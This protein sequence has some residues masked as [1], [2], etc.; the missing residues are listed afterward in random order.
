MLTPVRDGDIKSLRKAVQKLNTKLGPTSDPTF[1]DISL[2]SAVITSLSCS[3]ATITSIVL[4]SVTISA[5]T[6][7]SA[8]I[9][10]LACMSATVSSLNLSDFT[11]DFVQFNEQTSFPTWVE[12]KLVYKNNDLYIAKEG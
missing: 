9:T 10:S 4:G 3:S 2:S 11:T 12:G 5:L 7:T 1:S 6:L 8:T